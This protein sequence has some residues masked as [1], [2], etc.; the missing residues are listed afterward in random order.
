MVALEKPESVKRKRIF[1][2][3]VV[4]CGQ[5]SNINAFSYI[6]GVDGT[7]CNKAVP[8]VMPAETHN[9]SYQFYL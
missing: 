6:T 2:F 5:D 7:S 1:P 4:F 9:R 8:I 3:G